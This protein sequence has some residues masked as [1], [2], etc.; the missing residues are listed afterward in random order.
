MQNFFADKNRRILKTKQDKHFDYIAKTKPAPIFY[1]IF[2]NKLASYQYCRHKF[3]PCTFQFVSN[4]NSEINKDHGDMYSIGDIAEFNR[5]SMASNLGKKRS[6]NDVL[7]FKIDKQIHLNTKDLKSIIISSNSKKICNNNS[8]KY[9]PYFSSL[10][11]KSKNVYIHS[12]LSY[13]CTLRAVVNLCHL[14]N[15]VKL[16][17][18]ITTSIETERKEADGKANGVARKKRRKY[19]TKKNGVED[20][21]ADLA[22]LV[23]HQNFM[24]RKQTVRRKLAD[25]K[26]RGG[27]RAFGPLRHGGEGYFYPEM[28]RYNS[29]GS[30]YYLYQQP[31]RGGGRAF[32]S[33]YKPS[34]FGE[35]RSATYVVLQQML[36]KIVCYFYC[37][38]PHV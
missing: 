15:N 20:Y 21:N 25:A 2:L 35:G 6:Q 9:G 5:P 11:S 13:K 10:I 1:C 23:C 38:T 34:N 36:T 32:A 12:H 14:G 18:F 7:K 27:A 28:K 24:I 3:L 16:V 26:K 22:R 29:F 30:P 37:K 33:Y 8:D 4:N 31:K 19:H 17:N